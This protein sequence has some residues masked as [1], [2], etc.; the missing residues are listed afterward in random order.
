[1]KPIA[2][3]AGFPSASFAATR[4]TGSDHASVTAN[5][6][7]IRAQQHEPIRATHAPDIATKLRTIPYSEANPRTVPVGKS[8]SK[9][10]CAANNRPRIRHRQHMGVKTSLCLREAV[11][12][13]ATIV[14]ANGH[15]TAALARNV[16]P[17]GVL[18]RGAG[19]ERGRRCGSLPRPLAVG[20]TRGVSFTEAIFVQ[21]APGEARQWTVCR[22]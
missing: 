8:L 13:T 21:R 6:L 10:F 9:N 12:E 22:Q 11:H 18:R 17:K 3:A 16:G 2:A 7:A 20:R 4:A 5:Q 15:S 19:V 1:M 14:A